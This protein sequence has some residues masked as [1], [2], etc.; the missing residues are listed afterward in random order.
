VVDETGRLLGA[1]FKT[2]LLF[3]SKIDKTVE[4]VLTRQVHA[5]QEECSIADVVRMFQSKRICCV[6]VLDRDR[7]LIGIVGREDV[8]AYYAKH[9][10]ADNAVF[11]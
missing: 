2:D 7:K 3:P 1:L 4:Q 6:P 8:L 11:G 9:S 10:Q 5:V